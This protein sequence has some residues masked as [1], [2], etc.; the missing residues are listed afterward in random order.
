MLNIS[1]K[2]KGSPNNNELL[3]VAIKSEII[4]LSHKR[5]AVHSANTCTNPKIRVENKTPSLELM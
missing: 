1:I 5:F 4:K 2:R 3:H